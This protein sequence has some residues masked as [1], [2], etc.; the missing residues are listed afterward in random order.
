[1]VLKNSGEVLQGVQELERMIETE[2]MG[3]GREELGFRGGAPG[4]FIGRDEVVIII[5]LPA[6]VG[7]L[8]RH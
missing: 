4:D 5:S 1:V 2:G 3:D 6:T 8:W 7:M